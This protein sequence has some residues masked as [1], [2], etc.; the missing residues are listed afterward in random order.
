[1]TRVVHHARPETLADFAAGRLDEARAVVVARH[2]AL[3][4]TSSQ[5]VSD[6]E[7]MGGMALEAAEPVEM[8]PDALEEIFRRA[9]SA[10]DIMAPSSD[11]PQLTGGQHSLLDDYI[12]NDFEN[13]NW[14]PVAPGLSQSIIPAQGYRNGVLRLLKIKPGTR[15]P[16]HTHK[17]TEL[18]LIMRGAYEDEIGEFAVGDIAD[19]DDEHTHSPKAIGDEPCICL[20]ATAAPLVFKTL[21]GKI[22]QPF[23]GL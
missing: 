13:V 18:T 14:R 17:S 10:A 21:S 5:L 2:L 8:A 12:K 16:K 23:I 6:F 4:A 19:L 15:M 7:A 3:S 22:A 20:I 11:A 9:G 1:M